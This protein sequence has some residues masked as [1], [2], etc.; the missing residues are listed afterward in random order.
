MECGLLGQSGHLVAK[1][2]DVV[3][4]TETGSAIT[5]SP[6]IMVHLAPVTRFSG[7]NAISN[8]V[9]QLM[10]CG[11]LGQNGRLVVTNVGAGFD[12]EN[13]SVITQSPLTMG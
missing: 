1:R 6:L 2:V 8:I 10:E 12:T 9:V 7:E 4:S 13:G 11:A 3:F 5:Q